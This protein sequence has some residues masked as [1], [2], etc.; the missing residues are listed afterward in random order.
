M[1]IKEKDVVKIRKWRLIA[2]AFVVLVVIFLVG[3][4]SGILSAKH[5][6]E[7]VEEKYA[8][9][10][11]KRDEKTTSAPSQPTPT[12]P[13]ITTQSPCTG[14]PWCSVRLPTN[15]IPFHYNLKIEVDFP[16]LKFNGTQRMFVK[17]VRPTSYVLFHYKLMR[18]IAWKIFKSGT[19]EEIVI[20][21][22]S[23][24]PLNEYFVI[25]AAKD[26]AIG[27]YEIEVK[28]AANVSTK[29]TGFY[30][31]TY[32]DKNGKTRTL[33]TT[34]FQP[35][36]ARKAFPCFDE[37]NLK[38][39][40]NISIVHPAEHV[41]LSNMPVASFTP[42]NADW[43]STT[44]FEKTVKM[45]TY[46]VAFIVCEF[47]F[48]ENVTGLARNIKMRVYSSQRQVE[49]TAYGLK[50]GTEMMTYLEGFFGVV[51]PMPK[52]DFVAI[53]DYG[54]G[55][56]EHW[57]LITYREA[58]LLFT[59]GV[60]S[61]GN[62]EGIA[63]IVAHECV[64]LWFG[65]LVT[66][67]WWNDLWVQEGMASYIEYYAVD[68]V[69][70]DWEMMT[71]FFISDWRSGM[72]LDALASS[73]AISLPVVH[74]RQIKEIFDTITYRKGSS[75]IRMLDHDVGPQKFRESLKEYLNAN[76]FAGATSDDLW[77]AF[78]KVTGSAILHMMK[79]WTLQ[80]GH[81]LIT[82]TRDTRDRSQAIATQEH[83]LLD[84][85]AKVT[86]KSPYNYK[87]VVPLSYVT[88][89]RPDVP[90]RIYLNMSSA[91]LTGLPPSKW[92]KAN[93]KSTGFFRVTYS[94]ENWRL[95]INQLETNHS[96][97]HPLDRA[98]IIDDAFALARAGKL[99]YKIALGTTKYL[100]E[101]E[102]SYVVWNVA[103]SNLN[104]MKKILSNRPSY[105][106]FK[107]YMLRKI[108]PML[109][110]IGWVSVTGHLD[111]YKQSLFLTNA[112][113]YGDEETTIEAKKIFNDWMYKNK[114]VKAQWRS[115][116]YST[117]IANG[118]DKEWDFVFSKF[119]TET[120]PTEK[121]KLQYALGATEVPWIL[122]KWL[123]Y[124]LNSSIIRTQDTV[125]VIT[126][127]SERNSVGRYVAWDFARANWVKCME[128]MTANNFHVTK[129]TLGI[130]AQFTTEFELEQV[131]E[132][133]K[134]Y[135]NAGAGERAR[136]QGSER[137]QASI[138]W[139]KNHA[140]IV[141]QW[142]QSEVKG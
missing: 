58:R 5:E 78:D 131:Q 28:F 52:L 96:V 104:Y 59:E 33:L 65:N 128:I 49:N 38:A 133:W 87:W 63:N 31:S 115:L 11:V 123:G 140:S 141:E 93:Y 13:Q 121:G 3:I 134:K 114:T 124:S 79:T 101:T 111:Q 50:L 10:K 40:F 2:G 24:Q 71:Q 142:L 109:L 75:I 88:E 113:S 67:K 22:A 48:K 89:D 130:T 92:I 138:D 35:T 112:L 83:F 81:P 1:I 100:N 102:K 108:K 8:S 14:G 116:I 98:S 43:M 23:P 56:T 137:I 105:S 45:S 118:G 99:D 76:R 135:P 68:K 72:N 136:F 103:L 95:L 7:K 54:S 6:R 21:S 57:G 122:R 62:R 51:Y 74:P 16:G 15:I 85:K 29:L 4:L 36:D 127:V 19:M 30:K 20:K 42:T 61:E 129:M 84:P 139:A 47:H 37:P 69:H 107:K 77:K 117:G 91:T 26:I 32:K 132:F 125:Y 53:P 25:E 66:C 70:P 60:S 9:K 97:F 110:G 120:N 80:M 46:L 82:I 90:R 94:D 44:Y 126:R 106:L 34:K 55:A 27:D 39:S 41:I 12:S 86:V 73:H 17:V 119:K 18:I 64:H